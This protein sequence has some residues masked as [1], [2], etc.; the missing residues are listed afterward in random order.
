MKTFSAAL[1]FVLALACSREPQAT[2][3]IA[4]AEARPAPSTT[5][6]IGSRVAIT[7]SGSP[8]PAS[9]PAPG[10]AFVTVA[11]GRIEAQR[12]L[13]RAHT[14]FHIQNQTAVAHELVVRGDT[15][16]ATGSLPPNGRTVIQLLLGTGAYDITCTTPGHQEHARFETYAPGV[17]LDTPAKAPGSR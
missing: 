10:T 7:T 12:L 5:S 13:P 2:D 11:S 16:S 6:T 17:P 8:P 3:T 4:P 9:A 14:I 15:G 1:V